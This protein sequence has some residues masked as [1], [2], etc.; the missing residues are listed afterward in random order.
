MSKRGKTRPSGH[1]HTV[2]IPER[3]EILKFLERAGKPRR[4]VRIAEGL[5]LSGAAEQEALEKRLRAMLRDGQLVQNRREGYGL[6]EKMDLVSGRVIGHPDG[7]GFLVPDDGGTDLFLPAREMRSLLHGDRALARI[8]RRDRQGRR[9]GAVV[10]V[11]E[12]ANTRVVGRF[13]LEGNIAFVVPDN[14]RIHQEILIPPEA[15]GKARSGQF[16]VAEIESYPTQHRQ[17]VGRVVEI[18]GDHAA[19]GMASAIA[20]RAYE[21]PH[22]W[23]DEV[24]S[25]TSELNP[26][27]VTIS[28][29]R[30]DL[31]KLSFVTI[32]GEDARDFDDAVYCERRGGGWCLWVAIADVSHYVKPGSALD[33]EAQLRGTSVY[34]PDRVVPMLP[35]VLSNELCSLKPGVDRLAMVCE[36]QLGRKGKVTSASFHEAVIRSAARL[37]YTEMA[38]LTVERSA[39]ARRRRAGLVQHLDD[40]YVLFRLLHERRRKKGM[41]DFSSTETRVVFDEQGRIEAMK[42]LVRNDAHR[43]IEEFM[44]TANVAAAEF[45]LRHKLP[46]MYRNHERPKEEKLA[47]LREFLAELGLELGGGDEPEAIDY[48]R[49]LEAVKGR[50]DAH[51]IETLLLRSLPLAQYGETNLGHFGLAFP[52]YTQFTSPIRRY[53]DLLVHRAIGRILQIRKD[54]PY[55]TQEVQRLGAQCSATERRA[56]EASRDAMQRLKCGFMED[57]VGQVFQG[58]ISAVT[59]F[60]LFV[61]LDHV[62]VE[63]LVHITAL[64]ND[65]YHFDPIRHQLLGERTSRRYR[66]AGRVTARVMRVDVDERKID[67][68][69]VEPGGGARKQAGGKGRKKSGRGKRR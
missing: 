45:L 51:L 62:F 47:D 42:E 40:L 43:L 12:R 5:G 31:R 58:T 24:I 4:A 60:G 52:A 46:A 18:I 26:D 41:L 67:F 66:L 48:A 56:D 65:Y 8:A 9:E 64:P 63:G 16:V 23:P 2:V 3:G 50:D 25:E 1:G 32:D 49:V 20:I 17:P 19:P 53:P 55:D 14:R 10:E 35:E 15:R 22:E 34:F 61:E 37:T 6:V 21:L 59:S 28:R 68:E 69:L 44:L 11:L 36:L 30:T 54:Y 38:Q 57:K 29:R 33:R 39:A 7:Y 27:K 13:F